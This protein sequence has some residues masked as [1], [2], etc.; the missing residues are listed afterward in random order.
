MSAWDGTTAEPGHP[1][2][3]AALP[4]WDGTPAHGPHPLLPAAHASHADPCHPNARNTYN[5]NHYVRATFESPDG[6]YKIGDTIRIRVVVD[7]PT[8]SGASTNFVESHLRHTSLEMETGE[9]N[10][11]AQYEHDSAVNGAGGASGR[12][13]YIYTVE[14]DDHS[15]DLDY[16]SSD[17]LHWRLGTFDM[18]VS[19]LGANCHLSTPG[20]S[21]YDG[22]P[23]LS[24]DGDIV[25]DGIVPRVANV[26]VSPPGE[27]YGLGGSIEFGVN[28][29]ETVVYSGPAPVLMLD[30]GGGE[31]RGANYTAGNGSARLTFAYVVQAGDDAPDVEYNGTAALATAGSLTD[32]AGNGAVLALSPNGSLG[33]SGPIPIDATRPAVVSVSSPN[34]TGPHTEGSAIAVRVSF[35]EDVDVDAAGG[36][37]SIALNTGAAAGVRHALYDADAST[38]RTLAFSYAVEEGDETDGLAYAN[39]AALSGNGGTIRDAAGNGADLTLADPGEAGPLGDAGPIRLDAKRP[40]VVSVSSPNGTGPHTEGSAI[41]VRVSFSEDVDV[42]A[43]GGTP[44]IAL[45]TGAAAGVRHAL[46]DADASTGRTLAFSYAVEEGDET[47]GLAYANAAALSGNGGTIRDAA[48]NGADLTLADPGEAGPLGDAG[49]IRLD[50]K[51]P[52]V[53]S[54]SS[55][56][57]SGAYGAGG[58]IAVHAGFSEDVTVDTAGG[59]PS[60]ALNAGMAGY[61]AAASTARTL[62]FSY[63]VEEGDSASDLGYADSAAL[64]LN[65]GAIRDAA[66]NDADPA[67]PDPGGSGLLGQAGAIR[68]DTEAPAVVSVSSP[69]ASG[70]YA[71]G[72]AIHIEVEFSEAVDVEGAPL[73]E[74]ETGWIDRSADYASGSGTGVLTFLYAVRAGDDADILGYTGTDALSTGGGSI[75]DEAGNPAD[76]ELPGDVSPASLRASSIGISAGGG[77]G[78]SAATVVLGPDDDAVYSNLTGRGNEVRVAINVTGLAGD[79]GGAVQFPPGGAVVET[80][81]ASVSFPPGVTAASVP[82]GGLLVLR[83]VPPGGLPP[84]LG[85]QGLAYDGS[86]AVLLRGVV[87][88]G[89][90]GGGRVAFDMP[91]RISLEGQ[92]GGRAFYIDG[93]PGGRIV[94]IDAACAADD[95]ARVDRHLN[96]TGECRIDS[97]DGDMV[98]YTYHLTRFGTAE[99]GSGAPPPV[100]HTCSV[101]LGSPSLD[102]GDVAPGGRSDPSEQTLINYGSA[103]FAQVG[104]DATRWQAGPGGGAPPGATSPI[105]PA[106]ANGTGE[107]RASSALVAR[108]YATIPAA[109]TE[110]GEGGREGA[111]AAVGE[112]T[113]VAR[114]LGG[115][116]TASLWFRLNLAPYDAVEGGVFVQTVSYNVQCSLP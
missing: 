23:S 102:I 107:G 42:D 6:A 61:E 44:S 104:I 105:L 19:G 22:R 103:P 18:Q 17:A 69:N 98:I 73:L 75:R 3:H 1:A 60:I 27:G 37:P 16:A 4:S 89:D 78:R 96:G 21:D 13:D 88:I 101:G 114:G 67:L 48:G 52:A 66:G 14:Q 68:I 41:A 24:V 81:F 26:T 20:T 47:D 116:D 70:A 110:V 9:T 12:A 5:A 58:T 56:N 51:R 11:F 71:A 8:I 112:G 93:S 43:A 109:A 83:A 49:P 90:D 15:D 94:P 76:L 34:G 38:G 39:A 87:E 29:S 72:D 108:V 53:V 84:G 35:S 113:A 55:P 115:G 46:Y 106:P 74:L 62:A 65:M 36:T 50:A 99:S 28:F 86:G 100:Y 57:A 31:T 111:Y 79:A 59:T 91:V 92:A 54:V 77:G 95:A 97:E 63:A 85:V 7:R 32:L 82:P 80:S 64:S 25:V 30:L 2:W 40:A 33:R 10:R 45:N